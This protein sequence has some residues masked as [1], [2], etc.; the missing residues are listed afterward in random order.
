MELNKVRFI[1]LSLPSMLYIFMLLSGT[2]LIQSSAHTR[3]FE[4]IYKS[5][6]RHLNGLFAIVI[7]KPHTLYLASHLSINKSYIVYSSMDYSLKR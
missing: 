2:F 6:L 5:H 4:I 3:M 7:S 1:E